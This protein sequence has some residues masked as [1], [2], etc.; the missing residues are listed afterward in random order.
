MDLNQNYQNY[1]TIPLLHP[2]VSSQP[3]KLSNLQRLGINIFSLIRLLRGLALIAYTALSLTLSNSPGISS[4]ES[5]QTGATFL[6]ATL[7]STRDILLG[8]LLLTSSPSSRRETS[9]ALL[10]LLLS[11]A[12]DCF[13]LIFAAACDFRWGNSLVEIMAAALLALGEHLL[14]YSM[15]DEEEGGVKERYCR[16]VQAGEDKRRRL[17]DWL[18][19]MRRVEGERRDQCWH[20]SLVGPESVVRFGS[21]GMV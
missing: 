12:A 3:F 2:N 13:V 15:S 20:G 16:V 14:L 17:D 18:E 10:L 7:L 11:D 4:P 21:P 19:G 8:S 5:P 1:Q 6:L 9:R